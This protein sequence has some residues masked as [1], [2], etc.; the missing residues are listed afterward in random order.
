MDQAPANAVLIATYALDEPIAEIIEAVRGSGIQLYV[1]G[2]PRK[3]DAGIRQG[4]RAAAERR[5]RELIERWDASA[6]NLG[7]LI[8]ASPTPLTRQPAGS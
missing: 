8:A 2:N 1:T 4:R 5:R 7:G 3:L 6:R